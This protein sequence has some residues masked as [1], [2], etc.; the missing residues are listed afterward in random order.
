[1]NA[2]LQVLANT[3]ELRNYFNGKLNRKV[4][5]ITKRNKYSCMMSVNVR[6]PVWVRP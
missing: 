5:V 1:M 3:T 6:K 2:V 4:W